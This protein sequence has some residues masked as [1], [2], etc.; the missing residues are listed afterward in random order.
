MQVSEEIFDDIDISK[1]SRRKSKKA[2]KLKTI[3]HQEQT[4]QYKLKTI[5]PKT[6][7]Q[8]EI[9]YAYEDDINIFIHGLAGTGKTFISLYL[10]LQEVLSG[11]SKKKKI[12]IVR[13]IVPTRDIG[14]LPG[15]KKDKM[16]E[17]EAPYRAICQELF[18][19]PN[20]YDTLKTRGIIDF[21]PTSFIR[22]MTIND[23]IIIADES[24]N[25]TFHELDSIITRIGVNTKVIFCADFRQ[26]DLKYKDEK[27]GIIDFM[28]IIKKIDEFDFFEMNEEDIVRSRIV[29]EYIIQKSKMGIC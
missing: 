15:N 11:K 1:S 24:Q 10:A 7:N 5:T 25:C 13:S 8:S 3:P 6:N 16:A 22:G 2:R 21:V 18:T 4:P 19:V 17:Y 26:S 20:A 23:T 29:K 14:F 28:N 9:F 27:S 12:A